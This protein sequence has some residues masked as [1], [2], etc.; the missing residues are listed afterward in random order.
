MVQAAKDAEKAAQKAAKAA[1]VANPYLW[2]S[3]REPSD[4]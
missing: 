2:N 4:P 3:N 1:E